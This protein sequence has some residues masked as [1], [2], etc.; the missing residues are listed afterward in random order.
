MPSIQ[1]IK[2][3]IVAV[4]NTRQITK[5][6]EMVSATKMRRSQII[7]LASRAYTAETLRILSFLQHKTSYLPEIMKPRIAEQTVI[8]LVTSDRGFAGSFNNNLFRA[9]E[10]LVEKKENDQ[11]YF[12]VSVGKKSEDYFNKKKIVIEKTFKNFGDFVDVGQTQPLADFLIQGYLQKKWD[13]VLIV[14][15]NFRSTLKQEVIIKEILPINQEKI[16]QLTKELVPETGKFSNFSEMITKID[17]RKYSENFEYLIEPD[18]KTVL[19]KLAPRLLE[20]AIYD[21]IIEANASEHSARMVAMKNASKNAEDLT[22]KLSIAY[23]QLRQSLITR[24]ISE[25]V[26]GAEALK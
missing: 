22:S 2:R 15:T 10:K 14:S 7:A 21:L 20:I 16:W 9:F 6:M 1:E 3:R 25:I 26:A 4:S 23:N 17:Q 5:A 12:Y 8:L 13:R 24:E 11:K 19:D 18:A